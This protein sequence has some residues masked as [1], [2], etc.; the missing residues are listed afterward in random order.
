[1]RV[2]K[3]PKRRDNPNEGNGKGYPREPINREVIRV[4]NGRD[5]RRNPTKGTDRGGT[6]R[7]K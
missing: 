3:E 5:R 6:V 4:D 2:V 1:M 7:T